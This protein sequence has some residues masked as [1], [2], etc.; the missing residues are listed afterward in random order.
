MEANDGRRLRRGT[1]A[2]IAVAGGVAGLGLAV[3][4]IAVAT[5]DDKTSPESSAGIGG[6]ANVGERGLVE[7]GPLGDEFAER[8][9]EAL[10]L[11]Q[12]DVEDA[13]ADL[14]DELKPE[15][16]DWEPGE[17]PEPPTQE[18][19]E[20]WQAEFAKSL[21]EAL[22]VEQAEV[23]AALED[24]R[25]ELEAEA[26]ERFGELRE[27]FRADL[28]ERLDEAVTDGTL[29]EA[30]KES[31]LKAYDAGILGGAGPGGPFKG[32]FGWFG[33]HFGDDRSTSEQPS[34]Q[35]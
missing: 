25:A 35:S 19:R 26:E 15:R 27:E 6:P 20:A 11:E 29:T 23:Q 34:T 12:A 14:R 31:V 33:L 4:G 30:D 7:H 22:G 2:R 17:R 16:P 32:D 10:G 9:A 8:L 18:E 5:A 24:I 1:T 28:V 13:L 21:A 3:G